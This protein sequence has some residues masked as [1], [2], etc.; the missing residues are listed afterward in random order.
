VENAVS[1]AS[2][3]KSHGADPTAV[4]TK[5]EDIVDVAAVVEV[6]VASDVIFKFKLGQ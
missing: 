6:G 5:H 2:R 1:V 4:V 3:E